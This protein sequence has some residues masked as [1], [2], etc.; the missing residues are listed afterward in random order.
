MGY[1]FA[2]ILPEDSLKTALGSMQQIGVKPVIKA[3]PPKTQKCGVWKT[4]S[5]SEIVYRIRSGASKDN[6]PEVCLENKILLGG[7]SQIGDRGINFA[8]VNHKT[9]EVT[10]TK[11]F[12]MYEGE[13]S[14]PMVDFINKIPVGSI[15]LVASHDDAST[16]L[17]D[18][19]KKALKDL[20]SKE[21]QNVKFRS[22]WVFLALKGGNIPEDIE[23]EKIIHSDNSKNRYGG[24]PAEIQIDGCLPKN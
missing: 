5:S 1:L 15:I 8:I 16:K 3:P 20:G 9:M 21:I 2:E 17:N 22:Q 10:E 13:F 7:A 11:T 14:G 6:L 12:D 19:A 23:R 24:W 4:C 18:A